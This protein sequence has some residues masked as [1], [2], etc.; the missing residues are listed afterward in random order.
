MSTPLDPNAIA[1]QQV[2]A[3]WIQAWAGIAQAVGAILA[4]GASLWI[5]VNADRRAAAA[6]RD[7]A[8]REIAAE[9]AADRRIQRAEAS[10][11]NSVVNG[12]VHLADQ[13]IAIIEERKRA[14]AAS[15]FGGTVMGAGLPT[16]FDDVHVAILNGL[17]G[18]ATPNV[19]TKSAIAELARLTDRNQRPGANSGRVIEMWATF[20]VEWIN[21]IGRCRA[22][23]AATLMD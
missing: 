3:A 1:L 22:R 2:Q 5:A 6:E 19:E 12:S 7:A 9:A 15:G 13:A 21:E 8:M 16:T 10:A 14:L 4:I 11:H 18:A 23:I 20:F 17:T